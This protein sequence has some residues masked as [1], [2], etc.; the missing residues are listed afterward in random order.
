MA[1]GLVNMASWLQAQLRAAEGLLEAVDRTVSHTV[2][3]SL[4]TAGFEADSSGGQSVP[5]SIYLSSLAEEVHAHAGG[6]AGP[7]FE[8]QQSQLSGGGASA[9]VGWYCRSGQ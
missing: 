7:V 9:Q 2:A 4:N 5:P 6:G 3:P 8:E 1:K